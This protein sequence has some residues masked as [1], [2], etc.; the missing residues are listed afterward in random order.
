MGGYILSLITEDE[1]VGG[2]SVH[3]ALNTGKY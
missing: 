1:L 3:F 2:V